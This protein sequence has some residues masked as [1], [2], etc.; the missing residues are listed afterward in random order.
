VGLRCTGGFEVATDLIAF[1]EMKRLNRDYV[2]TG[3][4]KGATATYSY[5]HSVS[6][7][8]ILVD[9]GCGAEADE[10]WSTS[11]ASQLND[12]IGSGV[13]AFNHCGTEK[14]SYSSL[15]GALAPELD[16]TCN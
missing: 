4:Y 12:L 7:K 9:D 14:P 8:N 16:N 2:D 15:I 10:A 13:I 1:A 3:S 5:L 11:P 6:G